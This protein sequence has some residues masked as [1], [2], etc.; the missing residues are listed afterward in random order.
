MKVSKNAV[1]RTVKHGTV[2]KSN[3]KS[4]NVAK[5]N[6]NSSLIEN[7][8]EKITSDMVTTSVCSTPRASRGPD[9]TGHSSGAGTVAR[10]ST[11]KSKSA[12][13]GSK[14]NSATSDVKSSKGLKRKSDQHQTNDL[15]GSDTVSKVKKVKTQVIRAKLCDQLKNLL[16][17]IWIVLFY[18]ESC[19]YFRVLISRMIK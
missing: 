7:D 12:S 19:V 3:K 17:D 18:N 11:V 9:M 2:P 10:V 16:S 8:S 13:D 5:K 1:K 6:K 14:K 15:P 4:D